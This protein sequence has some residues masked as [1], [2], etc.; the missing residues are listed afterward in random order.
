MTQAMDLPNDFARCDGLLPTVTKMPNDMLGTLWSI[1][2]PVR[3]TCARYLQIER[4][5]PE[6]IYTYAVHSHSQ[7]KKCPSYIK[8]T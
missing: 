8:E 1:D 5:N 4:D 7:D 3:E 2:C 6:A